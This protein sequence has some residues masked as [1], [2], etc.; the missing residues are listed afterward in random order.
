VDFFEELLSHK[1]ELLNDRDRRIFVDSIMEYTDYKGQNV[2]HDIFMLEKR[3]QKI[4]LH[5][6]LKNKVHFIVKPNPKHIRVFDPNSDESFEKIFVSNF[7]KKNHLSLQPFEM[8]HQQPIEFCYL[9]ASKSQDL[10][11]MIFKSVQ[12]DYVIITS[13]SEPGDNKAELIRNQIVDLGFERDKDYFIF[14][15][16]PSNEKVP[17]KEEIKIYFALRFTGKKLDEIADK[18]KIKA[19][20]DGQNIQATFFKE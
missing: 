1:Y 18:L 10:K 2:F 20:L 19:D 13:E 12:A 17:D 9:A 7:K 15:D 3:F 6:V 5:S 14:T 4:F 8:E 16:R 11:D